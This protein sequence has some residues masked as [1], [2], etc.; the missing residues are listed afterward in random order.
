MPEVISI[1]GE[2]MTLVKSRKQFRN[3][4]QRQPDSFCELEHSHGFGAVANQVAVG[5]G[6]EQNARRH[7]GWLFVNRFE[8]CDSSFEDRV[9]LFG[10]RSD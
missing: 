6:V 8:W 4:D 10:H 3:D 5:V 7:E 1:F 9:V 2:T